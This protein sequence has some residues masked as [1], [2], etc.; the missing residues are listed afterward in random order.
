MKLL[1]SFILI[2]LISINAVAFKPHVANYQLS[3]NGL[4]I[5][6][7]VRTLHQL[8]DSYFYTANAKTS[9]LAALIKDYSIAA[10]S[11]FQLNDKGVSSI[12]YQII[13]QKDKEIT[14]SYAIDINSQSGI[15][16]SVPTKTQVKI[17]T[18]KTTPGNITDPL[19]VFL[20][21]SFDLQN[22]PEQSLFSYQ[23]AD[24]SSIEIQ[25]FKKTNNQT[26]S[27]QGKPYD[28]IKVE[29]INH[30]GNKIQVYFLS[31]YQYLPILIKQT[32]GGRNYLYEITN[33]KM[34][35]I[36]GLQVTL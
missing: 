34:S 13:E 10:S 5:A 3:I 32:K 23:I 9:G 36:K 30:Q 27:V 2:F 25:E 28:A 14:K 4:K 16:S 15:V 33:L 11:T 7:E 20:A 29:R 22:N 18:W 12:T 31:E 26:I 8:E 6:E 35:D 21:M 19:T 24:G 1:F 17:K